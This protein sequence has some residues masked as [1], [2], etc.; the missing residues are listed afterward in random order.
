MYDESRPS[1]NVSPPLERF[2]PP[3]LLAAVC[4]HDLRHVH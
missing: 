3:I 1:V 4:E 2:E